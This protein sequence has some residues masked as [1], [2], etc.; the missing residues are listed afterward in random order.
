M[1]ERESDALARTRRDLESEPH[2]RRS[3]DSTDVTWQPEEIRFRGRNQPI[4][5]C[6]P[7]RSYSAEMSLIEGN[8]EV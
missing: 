7:K 4:N 6:V 5:D 8:I 1:R 3:E 2:G